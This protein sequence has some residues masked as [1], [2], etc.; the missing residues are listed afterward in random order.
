MAAIMQYGI[1]KYRHYRNLLKDNGVANTNSP[2]DQSR[3]T[4]VA[5]V[6]VIPML[7]STV[8]GIWFA[9]HMIIFK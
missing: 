9:L 7:L 2:A 3:M 1:G 4:T 5:T 8:I 6:F